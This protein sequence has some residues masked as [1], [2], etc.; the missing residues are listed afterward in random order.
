MA[1]LTLI[2]DTI[3]IAGGTIVTDDCAYILKLRNLPHTPAIGRD[4]EVTA[5]GR[6]IHITHADVGQTG[7]VGEPGI[8]T[9]CSAATHVGVYRTTDGGNATICSAVHAD[10]R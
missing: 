4:A 6:H 1:G 3:V 10:V 8:A 5:V 2:K 9:I 7:P